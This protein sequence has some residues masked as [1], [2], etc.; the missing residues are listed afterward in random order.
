MI[1]FKNMESESDFIAMR[2]I[3]SEIAQCSPLTYHPNPSSL[4]FDRYLF[5][6]E[7][8]D[9]YTYGKMVMLDEIVIGYLLAYLE[10][11]GETEFVLRLLPRFSNCCQTVLE[12]LFAQYPTIDAF[13]TYSNS[14]NPEIHNAF[15]NS[16]FEY[17]EEETWQSVLNLA[18]YK[19]QPVFWQNEEIHLLSESDIDDRVRYAAIPSNKEIPR[20]AYEDLM[21]S[22]YYMDALDYVVRS[23]E[24]EFIAFA[25]W[26]VDDKSKTAVLEPVACLRDFRRRGI[27]KRMLLHGLNE[28]KRRGIK[29]AYVGTSIDN[30]PALALYRSVGFQKIGEIRCYVMERSSL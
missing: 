12:S 30:E 6:N 3:E 23:T 9:I 28:L 20:K 5:G 19:E 29:Y 14:L 22:D 4:I 18:E 17:G 27:T 16:G 25:T 26:W 21:R 15:I 7:A 2:Y 10:Y 1:S 13:T 11:E 24:G 8:D